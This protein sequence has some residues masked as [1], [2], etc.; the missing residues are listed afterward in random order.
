MPERRPN[1][2][3]LEIVVWEDHVGPVAEGDIPAK[4]LKL[5]TR[6][7]VGWIVHETKRRL[8]IAST[9]DDNGAEDMSAL[10]KS[11]VLKRIRVMDP[12]DAETS[13]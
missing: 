9:L 4:K 5:A 7:T 8:V 1:E 11:M 13:S 12:A 3:P 6:F 2:Y 10:G